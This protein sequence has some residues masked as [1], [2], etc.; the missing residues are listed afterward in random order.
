MYW[1]SQGEPDNSTTIP[2]PLLPEDADILLDLQAAFVATYG[3][4]G[5]EYLVDYDSSP[6][7]PFNSTEMR[8]AR[9]F[10]TIDETEHSLPDD[11]SDAGAG[12]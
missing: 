3:L 5:Y 8:L 7:I 4:L 2:I 11:G 12:A 9:A 10:I 6:E 1:Q